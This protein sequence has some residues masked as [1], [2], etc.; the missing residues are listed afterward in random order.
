MKISE[1]ARATG[2]TVPTIKYY[3][4]EGLMAPGRQISATQAEYHEGHAERLRL[5]RALVEVGGVS[6]TVGG[7]LL[8]AVDHAATDEGAGPDPD[9]SR[10]PGTTR[11]TARGTGTRKSRKKK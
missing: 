2:V 3:V 9:A 4:R 8:A 1:L 6:L 11:G 10:A 5:V 7:E